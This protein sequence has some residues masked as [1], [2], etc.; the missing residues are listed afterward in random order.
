M[1]CEDKEARNK[2]KVNRC[3]PLNFREMG[4]PQWAKLDYTRG[5]NDIFV[6]VCSDKKVNYYGLETSLT[7]ITKELLGLD[8]TVAPGKYWTY[9]GRSISEI[10][11]ETY[12]L[13]E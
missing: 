8:Y 3:P 11:N 10:Y 6:E 12:A 13:M 5:E 2:L 1:T 7:A 4:I 9:N